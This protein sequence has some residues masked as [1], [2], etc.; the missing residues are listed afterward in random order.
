M[1]PA[2]GQTKPSQTRYST[3]T[4]LRCG[5]DHKRMTEAR[6]APL[7]PTDPFCRKENTV[8]HSIN[9]DDS[10]LKAG[11]TARV[12]VFLDDTYSPVLQGTGVNVRLQYLDFSQAPGTVEYV[13]SET[14]A[15]GPNH[16]FTYPPTS[17]PRKPGGATRMIVPAAGD[18]PAINL[19]KTCTADTQRP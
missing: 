7:H 13:T 19:S 3:D 14:G 6:S 1:S 15:G 18:R 10:A 2:T 16:L 5:T 4:H 17:T 8:A 11:E 12:T 9:M